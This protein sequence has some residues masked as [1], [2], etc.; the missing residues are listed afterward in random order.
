MN[1]HPVKVSLAATGLVVAGAIL[2]VLGTK[3]FFPQWLAPAPLQAA[4]RSPGVQITPA[5]QPTMR[6]LKKMA[7]PSPSQPINNPLEWAGADHAPVARERDIARTRAMLGGLRSQL[8]LYR[9]QHRDQDPLFAKYP[10]WYPLTR[11]TRADGTVDPKGE[12]GPYLNAA[13]VNPM[14]GF[15][16]IGLTK[17]DPKPGQALRGEKLGWVFCVTT[18][19]LHAVDKDGRTVLAGQQ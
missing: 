8:E 18:H 6:P 1:N 17:S 5:T 9:L 12:L 16:S 11:A 10:A 7:L 19:T 15:V 13:P 2:G 3:V 14:N 4:A